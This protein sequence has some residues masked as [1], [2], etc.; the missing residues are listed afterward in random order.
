MNIQALTLTNV[1]PVAA[2]AAGEPAVELAL[3]F[4]SGALPLPFSEHSIS[5]ARLPVLLFSGHLPVFPREN[6]FSNN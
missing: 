2:E 1:P 6:A 4:R 5:F 3:D